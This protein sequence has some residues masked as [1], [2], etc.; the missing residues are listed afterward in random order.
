MKR[1]QECNKIEKIWRYRFYLLIPFYYLWHQFVGNKECIEQNEDFV[2]TG[3]FNIKG[4]LLWSIVKSE[5][6]SKMNWYYTMDE[7]KRKIDKKRRTR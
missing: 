6:Q 3:R 5:A 1:F 7:V 4:K 2:E